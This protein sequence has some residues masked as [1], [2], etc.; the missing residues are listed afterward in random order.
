LVAQRSVVITQDGTWRCKAR[1][2]Q[3]SSVG[4]AALY[5]AEH[6]KL[7]QEN[8]PVSSVF[9]DIV[10]SRYPLG[11]FLC[12]SGSIDV[13]NVDI[14]PRNAVDLRMLTP[15]Y[16][17]TVGRTGIGQAHYGCVREGVRLGL[18]TSGGAV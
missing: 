10:T 5:L 3:R 2:I 8:I 1:K 14:V 17:G 4:I 16:D 9:S 7:V 18:Q 15:S 13:L 12:T 11:P 6:I